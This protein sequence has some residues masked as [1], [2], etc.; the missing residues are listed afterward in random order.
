[1]TSDSSSSK[2]LRRQVCPPSPTI[3]PAQAIAD[4]WKRESQENQEKWRKL[5]AEVKIRYSTP[6]RADRKTKM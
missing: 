3:S 4:A 2:S 1:M 6:R 5:D